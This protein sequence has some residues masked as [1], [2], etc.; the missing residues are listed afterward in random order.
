M[1]RQLI[2]V[3]GTLAA[4]AAMWTAPKGGAGM[5]GFMPPHYGYSA[6][7]ESAAVF[8]ATWP[9]AQALLLLA[10]LLSTNRCSWVGTLAGWGYLGGWRRR[11]AAA[12]LI[13]VAILG[14]GRIKPQPTN[15]F[16]RTRIWA[17]AI[18][19]PGVGGEAF[20]KT[21][22]FGMHAV[23]AHSELLQ[24][25]VDFGRAAFVLACLA[26][27]YAA[28]WL[29]RGPQTPACAAACCVTV[30]L[31]FDNRLHY[32]PCA[33]LFLTT[34]AWAWADRRDLLGPLYELRPWP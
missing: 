13:L 7:F 31:L 16:V 34:W 19:S 2:A 11:A 22:I 25:Y 28:W 12:A 9:E 17:A 14:G 30:Q 32:P 15:D 29:L 1:L 26:M 6:Y 8:A 18:A 4:M 23:K 21:D 10:M 5:V 24:V 3:T 27:L 33:A 20:A